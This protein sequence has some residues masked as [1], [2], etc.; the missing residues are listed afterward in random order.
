MA[1]T[2]LIVVRFKYHVNLQITTS[3]NWRYFRVPRKNCCPNMEVFHILD[4]DLKNIA[5]WKI[6]RFYFQLRMF[7]KCPRCVTRHST[8]A[9]MDLASTRLL[10]VMANTT[11]QMVRMNTVVV[12]SSS[13]FVQICSTDSH[14]FTQNWDHSVRHSLKQIFLLR[15]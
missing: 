7:Q 3:F 12:S 14:I 5:I 8:N 15:F 4:P 2:N 11:V 13:S 6:L 10:F 1:Q 9:K